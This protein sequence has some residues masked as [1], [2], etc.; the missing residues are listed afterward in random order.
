MNVT[1]PCELIGFGAMGDTTH[2]PNKSRLNLKHNS[3]RPPAARDRPPPDPH[4]PIACDR[5][6]PDPTARRPPARAARAGRLASQAGAQSVL[7]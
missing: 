6:P 2:E 3:P 1:K 4:R 7:K 5:P